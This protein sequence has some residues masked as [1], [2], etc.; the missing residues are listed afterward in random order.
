MKI[1][2][3]RN[4]EMTLLL[5][6]IGKSCSYRNFFYIAN[7]SLNAICENKILVNHLQYVN[8]IIAGTWLAV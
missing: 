1:K 4:G 3:L 7:R 8:F 6:G 2:L 5:T